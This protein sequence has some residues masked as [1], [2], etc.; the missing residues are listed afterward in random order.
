MDLAIRPF[1]NTM[2]SMTGD[3]LMSLAIHTHETDIA[4]AIRQHTIAYDV[5]SKLWKSKR[6]LSMH[7]PIRYIS[8][9]NEP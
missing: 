5:S 8:K 7:S 6:Y 1:P 3:F 9:D 4:T 2:K